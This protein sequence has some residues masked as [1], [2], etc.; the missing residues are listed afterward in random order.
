MNKGTEERLTW[1]CQTPTVSTTHQGCFL[2]EDSCKSQPQ[3]TVLFF[4]D[5]DLA[6]SSFLDDLWYCCK[7]W[8]MNNSVFMW[9]KLIFWYHVNS[10]IWNKHIDMSPIFGE[11]TKKENLLRLKMI[12]SYCCWHDSHATW[13]SCKQNKK[14]I[15]DSCFTFLA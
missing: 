8:L 10:H 13:H 7:M 5:P 2:S 4:S 11:F 3:T 12:L 9:G 15:L 14:S 1:P 6:L